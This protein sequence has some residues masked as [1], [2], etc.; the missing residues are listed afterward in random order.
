MKLL[1]ISIAAYNVEAYIED[2]LKSIVEADCI[3][4]IE[5]LIVDDGSK[6]RTAEISKKYASLYPESIISISKE[7][8]G[9]GSTVNSSIVEASGKYYKLLDG[10]DRVI[11]NNLREFIEKLRFCSDD[12]ILTPYVKFYEGTDKSEE[13]ELLKTKIDRSICIEDFED[14]EDICMHGITIRTELLKKNWLGLR[15]HCLYLDNVFVANC[16]LCANS[17]RYFDLAIY[18]YRIGRAGQSIDVNSYIKHFDDIEDASFD[19]LS[20]YENFEGKQKVK[21]M[22]A[23][24]AKAILTTLHVII[25]AME[26]NSSNKKRLIHIDDMVRM[27]YPEVYKLMQNRIV[28]TGRLF[29]YSLYPFICKMIHYKFKRDYR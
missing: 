28:K 20:L 24:R 23:Y 9:W 7:N 27:K 16:L 15:E 13:V 18:D 2:T 6:D 1:S 12:M 19:V 5:I 29:H 22:I 21:K 11:T 17:I 25:Y 4:D 26:C 8:G 3:D 10:D 14:Y